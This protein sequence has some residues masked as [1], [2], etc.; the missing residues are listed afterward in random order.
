MKRIKDIVNYNNAVAPN[1][2]FDG[3]MLDVEPGA[4]FNVSTYI[5]LHQCLRSVLPPSIKLGTAINAFWEDPVEYPAGGGTVKPEFAH[6]IDLPLDKVLVMGYR[7]TAGTADCAAGDGLICLDQAEIAYASSV[8]KSGVVMVGLETMNVTPGQ[9]EKVSFFEEGDSVLT[10]EAGSAAAHFS[11]ET[12]FG[13]FSVHN[14]SSSY[15]GG[16][17]GWPFSSILGAC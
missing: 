16:S 9:P 6:I 5:A 17:S 10:S 7:D 15:L 13:G 8:G 2:R 4:A 12:G 11:G 3:V 14:Y 1:E